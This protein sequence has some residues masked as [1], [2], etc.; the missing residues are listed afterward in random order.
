[1]ALP[2]DTIAATTLKNYRKQLT[3]NVFNGHPLLFWL[4][5]KKRVRFE[6]GGEQIVEELIYTAGDLGT[7]TGS[8]SGYDAI[9]IDPVQ[10]ATAAKFDWK[11][12]AATIAISGLEELKNNGEQ[13]MSNLLEAKILQ[14]EETLK[15]ALATMLWK[16]TA[17]ANSGKDVTGIGV[18]IGDENSAVTTVGGI[19]C[20]TDGPFWRSVVDDQTAT[21]AGDVDLRA[22]VRHN[23]NTASK[24]GPDK[25]DVVFSGQAAFEQYEADLLPTVR[26]TNSKVA[27]AGFS[28]LEVQGVPW[29]WD[30]ECPAGTVFG[31]NSKYIGICGHSNRWFKQSKF[32]EG[33]SGDLSAAAGGQATTVDARYSV[34]TAALETTVRNRRR[35]FRINN[36]AGV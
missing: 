2:F 15:Q 16:S 26:R 4:K 19:D 34:I 1:M 29:M 28:N 33:L 7:A 31:I 20:V 13:R 14:A 25:V 36:I 3:D 12:I 22:L 11:Q 30:Y 27:D 24:G 17:P 23:Y 6:D 5:D 10:T 18:L 21:A 8:Y 32:T 9:V 35:Q